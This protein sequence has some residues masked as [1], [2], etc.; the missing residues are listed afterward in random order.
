MKKCKCVCQDTSTIVN[1]YDGLNF[2][3]TDLLGK[4]LR[5]TGE[6]PVV[7]EMAVTS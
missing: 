4:V 2:D 1:I 7:N 6:D 3:Y 5:K